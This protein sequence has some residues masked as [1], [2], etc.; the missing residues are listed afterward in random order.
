MKE[1]LV[2]I[3]TDVVDK[4]LKPREM[5]LYF[6]SGRTEI[7]NADDPTMQDRVFNVGNREN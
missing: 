1:Y 4:T 3:E 6:S 7:C 2:A 5:K